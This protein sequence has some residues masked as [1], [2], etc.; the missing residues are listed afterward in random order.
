MPA[1]EHF[2]VPTWQRVISFPTRPSVHSTPQWTLHWKYHINNAHTIKSGLQN[3]L[4]PPTV[5]SSRDSSVGT[6]TRYALDGRETRSRWHEFSAPVQTGPGA[7]LAPIQWVPEL[8]PGGKEA[9]AW[10]YP[11]TP[12]TAEVKERVE[13]HLYFPSGP[14]WPVLV[15]TLSLPNRLLVISAYIRLLTQV[16]VQWLKTFLCAVPQV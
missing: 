15:R 12:S 2:C 3:G 9:G 5:R 13:L 1:T 8:F 10:R 11:P 14:S 7:H 4:H 16:Q 6:A